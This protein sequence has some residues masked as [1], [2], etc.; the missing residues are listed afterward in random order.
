LFCCGDAAC[1]GAEDSCSCGLDC[2]APPGLEVPG[3]TCADGLDND[4]DGNTDCNDADCA[5]DPGCQPPACDGDG[6]C[7]AGED[8]LSCGSDC[9]GRSTGKPANRYCCGDGVAQSAEG[10]G[11]LCDGNF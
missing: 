5:G 9:A 2:G 6:I 11:T 4:C 3:L 8:C 7:E 10:D 1:E